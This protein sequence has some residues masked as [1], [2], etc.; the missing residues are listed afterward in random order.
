MLECFTCGKERPDRY[1]KNCP[2]CR[3]K[4]RKAKKPKAEDI[5]LIFVMDKF[6]SVHCVSSRHNSVSDYR[7]LEGFLGWRKITVDMEKLNK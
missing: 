7:D 6:N 2:S 4:W 3:E 5:W 1:Y